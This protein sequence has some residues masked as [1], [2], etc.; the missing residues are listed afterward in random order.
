[1]MLQYGYPRT[2][3]EDHFVGHE[4][5]GIPSHFVAMNVQGQITVVELPGGNLKGAQLLVGPRLLGKGADLAPVRL[6]FVGEKKHP[7]LVVTVQSVQVRFHNTGASY[8][9]MN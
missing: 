5:A 3:Q 9:P 2:A 1:M 7:D 8:R 4:Q 6:E